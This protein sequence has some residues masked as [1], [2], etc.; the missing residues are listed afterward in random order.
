MVRVRVVRE[1]DR[2]IDSQHVLRLLDLLHDAS[3]EDT[4]SSQHLHFEQTVEAVLAT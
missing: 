3:A 4:V 1:A 2:D